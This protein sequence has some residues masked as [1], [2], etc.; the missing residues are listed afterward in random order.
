MKYIQEQTPEEL[1]PW[2][3]QWHGT[4]FA[5]IG[6]G[7]TLVILGFLGCYG[8]T[9]EASSM[10]CCYLVFMVIIMVAEATAI[11]FMVL[12]YNKIKDIILL[13]MAQ[14]TE[15]PVWQE[16]W[17]QIQSQFQCCG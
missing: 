11:V 17:N 9:K 7:A 12:Y 6:I 4:C 1:E 14:Y 15:D 10:L 16:R 2:L 8:A 13:T 3:S 5:L